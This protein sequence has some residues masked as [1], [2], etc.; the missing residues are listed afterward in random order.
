MGKW[1]DQFYHSPKNPN[2]S[3]KHDHFY[4]KSNNFPLKRI[5]FPKNGNLHGEYGKCPEKRDFSSLVASLSDAE[6]S[7]API[8]EVM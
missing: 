2:L 3:P 5:N 7:L 6:A 1:V 4:T 8:P